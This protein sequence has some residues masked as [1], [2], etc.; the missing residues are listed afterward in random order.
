[1]PI[2]HLLYLHG[3][4]SSPQS[5]KA[6]KMAAV[7]ANRYPTVHWWCPQLPPSPQDAMAMLEKGV[8]D[9]PA[10]SMAVIG[11]SLGGFYATTVAE[12][13]GCKA[14][15]LNPA[16]DPAR[17]LAH[18]I[19]EQTTWQNPDEHFFF[20]AHFVDELRA[21]QPGPLKSPQHYLA[22]IAKG[23]EVLDWREMAVR[24]AGAQL[25]L[26]EGGDHALSDFDVHLP[27]ILNFLDLT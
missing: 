23:D 6:Q 14:V 22:L 8:A 19:G 20:E 2:T 17:D 5:V 24:Y 10:A 15:L 13:H 27:A 16:V 12:R 3:F 25:R 7:M 26:L 4:R 9:W 11:S 21:L 18:Y 1:M